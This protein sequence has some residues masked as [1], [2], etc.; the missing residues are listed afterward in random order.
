MNKKRSIGDLKDDPNSFKRIKYELFD[1]DRDDIAL[2]KTQIL[3]LNLSDDIIASVYYNCNKDIC[4]TILTIMLP[5]HFCDP[6]M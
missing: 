4:D 5:S 1:N 6:I 3:P 2:I